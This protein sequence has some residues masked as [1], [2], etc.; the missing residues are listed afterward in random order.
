MAPERRAAYLA[1]LGLEPE[2]P[3][4]DALRRLHQA[5]AERVPYETLWIHLGEP[6]G[7]DPASSVLR[8]STQRRGGYCFHLNGALGALLRALGYDVTGHVGGVHGP[9]GPATGDL[10]NHLVLTVDGLPSDANPGGRWY[11]DVGLGDALHAPLP[12]VAGVYHQAPFRLELEETPGGVGDWHLVHDSLGGF[13]GMAWRRARAE[14]D[15]FADRH[16]WLS[17][18]PDSGFV[19]VLTVQQ[20]DATGVDVLRGLTLQRVGGTDGP[21]T[22]TTQV[23][24]FDVLGDLFGLDVT[25]VDAPARRHLWDR[26]R[27]THEAWEAAG[28]P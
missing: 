6:L 24:V 21:V 11:V 1:R 25:P 10:T 26:L 15:Q 17:T 8:L 12:L 28:R 4:I 19:R 5:H 18:S 23:E 9:I 3:S 7:I 20:R 22:L 2:P 27:S 14:M 16:R 13:A